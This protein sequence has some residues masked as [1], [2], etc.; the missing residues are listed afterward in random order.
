[1]KTKQLLA[2]LACGILLY[3]CK[4][5]IV[6]QESSALDEVSTT[7]TAAPTAIN[8]TY[9]LQLVNDVRKTGCNCGTTKMPPVPA[10]VWNSLLEKAA[11]NHSIDMFKNNYF[12]HTGL[13]GS[14]PGTRLRAVGYNWRTYGENIALGY[15]SELAVINGWL[16]S[17]GHCRNIMNANF[18]EMGVERSGNCWTQDFGARL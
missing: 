3:S 1:V 4:K 14:T 17:P 18:K 10:L 8:K 9:L 2:L 13:N 15:T 16:K 6:Q 11:V 7:V 12:S 5:E